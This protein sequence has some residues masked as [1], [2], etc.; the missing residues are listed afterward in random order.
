MRQQLLLLGLL[1]LV[2]GQ[3]PAGFGSQPPAQSPAQTAALSGVVVDAT[4]GRPVEGASVT[5]RRADPTAVSAFSVPRMVTDPKGRFVFRDLPPANNY[6]IDVSRFGYATM[7]YGWSGPDGSSALRDIAR[8]SLTANQW[9]DGIKVSLYRLGGISGRVVDERGEPVVGTA[10]RVFSQRMIAGREQAVGG[11]IA[12]TDDRGVYRI[13]GLDP[14][15]YIVAALSV[16]HTVLDTIPDGAQ[17]LP[18]GEL[19]T[20]GIGGSSG[21]AVRGPT[22]D[23]DGRHR[24]ALTNFATPPPPSETTR[25]AYRATFYPDAARPSEATPIELTYGDARTSIDFQLRP[26]AAFRVSGRLSGAGGPPAQFLLRLLP[27]GHE[28]L[29]FGAEAATTTSDADGTFTF[30]NVPA[31]DYTLLAQASVMDFNTGGSSSRFS[32]APGFPG[33]GIS[34]GSMTGTPGVSYLTRNGAPANVWGRMPV[35]VGAQDVR[36]LLV[37]LHPTVKVRGRLA[38]MPGVTP[39]PPTRA[40]LI[41]MQPANG[42]PSLGQPM[43]N[44]AGGDTTFPFE[45]GGLMAGAYVFRQGFLNMRIAS[46][47]WDGRD[48]TDAGF[49]ASAGRDFDG[50]VVTL[51][52]KTT[53]LAGVV[54]DTRG[55]VAAAVIAFP[56]NRALWTNYGWDPPRIRA[57]RSNQSGEYQLE[58]LPEGEY[59]LVA[60]PMAKFDARADPKF[61]AAAAPAATPFTIK[62]DDKKTFN[63]TLQEVVVK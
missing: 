20:G 58:G 29:G 55:P 48:M 21:N 1:I 44:T 35:G 43:G 49:D 8:I 32:D 38:F 39:P 37:P 28:G 57:A 25:R 40:Q 30:L 33:G 61:L 23:V 54:S 50:V 42:D 62:W 27:A 52:D 59:L 18:V 60:V 7:R 6:F 17:T 15:R 16:Q 45:V 36:D 3:T 19:A 47:V 9:L 41:V 2:W 34:V 24:L 63:L 4:T 51:T 5:L 46:V 56:S 11:P 22:I 14:A 31:G 26:V 13:S 10:V 53:T 12:V